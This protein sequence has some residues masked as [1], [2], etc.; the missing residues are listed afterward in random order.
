[1]KK[2]QLLL[3][4]ALLLTACAQDPALRATEGPGHI[5]SMTLAPPADNFSVPRIRMAALQQTAAGLG[6][7]GGLAWTSKGINASL[8]RDSKHL[9]AVFNFRA[10]LLN[11]NVLPPV[12]SEGRDALNIDTPTAL[13]LADKIYKIESPP[14][15]V[16]APPTWREYVWMTYSP[17]ER[18]NATLLPRDKEEQKV[19]DQSYDQGWKDGV[20]QANQIF[21]ENMGRL[22]RD[23]SGMI[24]YRKLLAQNMVTA[25]F[26]AKSDLGITGD[27]N[28]LRINDQ[29]LRITSTSELVKNSK[30]WKTVVVPGVEGAV[31]KQGTEGTQ[32]LQ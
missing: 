5:K 10:L 4:I 32:T 26:V 20:A 21:S 27:V 2:T 25:P 6:A 8:E 14:R 30:Q 29:V 24:L 1:M 11:N 28:E 12:L 23:Y 13:R 15:F 16:T 3:S 17:P 18:P 9:S 22:K 31:R 7:Q 19:W